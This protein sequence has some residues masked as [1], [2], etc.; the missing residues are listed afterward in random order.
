[1][2]IHFPSSSPTPSDSLQ[3]FAK[4]AA[5]GEEIYL[6][7]QK[8]VVRATGTTPQ[9]RQVDWAAPSGDAAAE[10]VRALEES[11]GVGMGKAIAHELG[12]SSAPGKPIHA[13]TVESAVEMA[14][15]GSQVL[16]GVDFLTRLDLSAT[17]RGPGFIAVCE[18]AGIQPSSLDAQARARI[19]EAMGHRFDQALGAGQSPVSPQQ[20]RN[21]LDQVL[22][23]GTASP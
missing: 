2:A 8:L 6:D 3:A 4:A 5:Q 9:G 12:L 21:W 7:G 20:A 15:V 10:L 18:R 1:M 17:G 13:R 14:A 16:E 22:R 11:S 23:S 19:D